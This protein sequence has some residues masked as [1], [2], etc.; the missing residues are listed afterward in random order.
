[1]CEDVLIDWF[2]IRLSNLSDNGYVDMHDKYNTVQ[3]H[4]Q[5]YISCDARVSLRSGLSLILSIYLVCSGS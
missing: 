3:L 5:I 1:M 2:F 4:I